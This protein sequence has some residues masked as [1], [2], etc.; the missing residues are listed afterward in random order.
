M[1][2]QRQYQALVEINAHSR[3][4]S[5]MS[6]EIGEEVYNMRNVTGKL[7]EKLGYK[8]G[9]FQKDSIARYLEL[10]EVEK[11]E[12]SNDS[13][14]FK[15]GRNFISTEVRIQLNRGRELT[16]DEWSNLEIKDIDVVDSR[17]DYKVYFPK[18]NQHL[19][20]QEKDILEITKTTKEI[21]EAGYEKLAHLGND[22]EV[23]ESK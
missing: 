17:T 14:K 21:T 8:E 22:Y 9:K 19:W 4:I 12:E 18:E 10:L 13:T 5:A 16:A 6:T 11:I 7:V 15:K 3:L 23:G 2:K 1:N 20:M